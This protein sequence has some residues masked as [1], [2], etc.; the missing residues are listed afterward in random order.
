MFI[1]A[2]LGLCD[3]GGRCPCQNM[4]LHGSSVVPLRM[5]YAL[6]G[7]Q[8]YQR[9]REQ[10]VSD[11]VFKISNGRRAHIRFLLVVTVTTS[12]KTWLAQTV[13]SLSEKAFRQGHASSCFGGGAGTSSKPAQQFAIVPV[14]I[15]S[16]Y[17]HQDGITSPSV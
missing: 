12:D 1:G 11:T 9:Q 2:R 13:I 10:S 16:V 5:L 6:C 17:R 15:R 14:V 8:S 3:I 4:V 7:F